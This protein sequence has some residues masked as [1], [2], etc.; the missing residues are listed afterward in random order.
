MRKPSRCNW[1]C[2]PDGSRTSRERPSR[3]KRRKRRLVDFM[4]TLE[5]HEA[6]RDSHPIQIF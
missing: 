5:G 1:L 6:V 3:S 4:S 2:R